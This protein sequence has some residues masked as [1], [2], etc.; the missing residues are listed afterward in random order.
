MG[1]EL[2]IHSFARLAGGLVLENAIFHFRAFPSEAFTANDLFILP[3]RS[4]KWFCFAAEV[5]YYPAYLELHKYCEKEIEK[6]QKKEKKSIFL[7]TFHDM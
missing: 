5:M 4:L 3:N 2:F 7:R 1:A 6:K